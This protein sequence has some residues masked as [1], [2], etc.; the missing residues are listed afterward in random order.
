MTQQEKSKGVV[1]VTGAAHRIGRHIARD[2]ARHGWKVAVHFNSSHE[3]AD[4]VVDL[5]AGDGGEAVAFGADLGNEAEVRALLPAAAEQLGPVTCLVNNASI[6]VPDNLADWDEEGIDGFNDHIDINLKAPLLL[7]RALAAQRPAGIGANIINILD[8]KVWR[9]TPYYFSYTLSKTALWTATRT[10]AQALAPD[11]RVNGIGPGP[12][13]PNARQSREE[14]D[15]QCSKLPLG[16]CADPDEIAH[17]IRF[18]L[19]TPSLT[20][21][22][23]ALDGGRHLAWNTPD[24]TN[25]HD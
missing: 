19:E 11:I 24:V 25:K 6:F 8:Q 18:I 16:R 4:A 13:L 14:F 3:K 21:Q 1:L 23:I 20:G 5:I 15:D 17:A 22:M 12:I 2:L 9:L 7:A 10:L